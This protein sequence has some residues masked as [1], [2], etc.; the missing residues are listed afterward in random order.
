MEKTQQIKNN[1]K[2]RNE[3][4]VTEIPI[5][6]KPEDLARV[7]AQAIEK[8]AELYDC[9][10]G[11]IIFT[12]YENEIDYLTRLEQDYKNALTSINQRLIKLLEEGING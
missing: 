3:Q 12:K 9:T 1:N 6:G 7:T 11:Y 4:Q 2:M 5:K 8:G 10:G